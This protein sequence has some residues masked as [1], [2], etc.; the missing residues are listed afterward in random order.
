MSCPIPLE[1]PRVSPNFF[2]DSN[3]SGLFLKD[4]KCF[5]LFNLEN[6]TVLAYFFRDPKSFALLI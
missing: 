6:L 3:S 5:D 1:T 4:S 2:R